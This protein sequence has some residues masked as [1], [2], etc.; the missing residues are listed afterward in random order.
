VIKKVFPIITCN[1]WN[2]VAI[3]KVD[4]CSE[5]AVLTGL[6]LNFLT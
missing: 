2:T 6:Q 5:S 1:P 4:P 3:N